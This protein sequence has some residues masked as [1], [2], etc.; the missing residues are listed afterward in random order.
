MGGGRERK[1]GKRKEKREGGR[2]HLGWL[3]ILNIS[4][5]EQ[6]TS[7]F[8]RQMVKIHILSYIGVLIF[9]EILGPTIFSHCQYLSVKTVAS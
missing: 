6:H 2:S 7:S 3:K 9:Q 5:W 4:R 8:E 1:E